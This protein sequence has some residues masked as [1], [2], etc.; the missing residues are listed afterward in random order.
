MKPIDVASKELLK[1]SNEDVGYNFHYRLTNVEQVTWF[2]LT[3][4]NQDNECIPD[5]S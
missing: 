4:R 1:Y 3:V 5:F 2:E